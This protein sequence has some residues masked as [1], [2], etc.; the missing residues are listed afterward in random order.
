MNVD[1]ITDHAERAIAR[2]AMQYADKSTI[3]GICSSV[4]AQ[5]QDIE[6]AIYGIY[7]QQ[8]V[9]T[10]SDIGLEVIGYLFNEK[11]GDLNDT[12]FRAVIM[13]KIAA[14]V[15][16]ATR[17]DMI[18][19]VEAIVTTTL[20][21]VEVRPGRADFEIIA[22]SASASFISDLVANRAARIL[23][24]AKAAGVRAIF[25]YRNFT[26]TEDVSFKY[27]TVGQ[28]YSLGKYWGAKD[29]QT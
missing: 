5:A 28:G 7:A 26:T 10:A 18:A 23:K 3:Q 25:K 22:N 16:N 15:G 2:L 20:D 19:V 17:E 24:I 11:R 9:A 4:G 8:D 1:Q 12:E 27:N 21:S 13:A 6:D 14:L 29:R